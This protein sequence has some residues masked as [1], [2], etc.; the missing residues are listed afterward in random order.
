M[1]IKPLLIVILLSI[2]KLNAQ[3]E[4]AQFGNYILENGEVLENTRIGYQVFGKLNNEFNN[5]ILF[6]TWY[7]GKGQSLHPYIGK[8]RMIDTTQ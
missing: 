2:F 7:G 6:P 3:V 4:I 5:A 1:N 8:E